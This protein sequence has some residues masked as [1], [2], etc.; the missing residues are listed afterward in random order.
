MRFE[1]QSQSEEQRFPK[2]AHCPAV[3]AL[4]RAQTGCNR[5]DSGAN[6]SGRLAG[7]TGHYRVERPEPGRPRSLGTATIFGHSLVWR[8]SRI[9]NKKPSFALATVGKMPQTHERIGIV[10][11]SEAM[12]LRRM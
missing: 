11:G 8:N 5:S 2:R 6:R 12:P 10:A 4:G 7:L 1:P 9:E 3:L